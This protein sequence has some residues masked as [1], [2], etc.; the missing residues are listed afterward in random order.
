M[1]S[2]QKP[3]TDL[4]GYNIALEGY[5]SI[6]NSLDIPAVI[7]KISQQVSSYLLQVQQNAAS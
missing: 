4:F 7:L 6:T 3:S 1:I 5:C 2:T